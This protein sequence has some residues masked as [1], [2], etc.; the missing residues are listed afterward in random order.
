MLSVPSSIK[1][2]L[3]AVVLVA[4]AP[5]LASAP[6]LAQPMGLPSMGAAS[7]SDLSPAME[8]ALGDLIIAQGRRD[9]TYVHDSEI[10]Q[11]LNDM[12]KRLARYAPNHNLHVDVFGVLS[13]QFNAFALPGGYIGINT[14]LI[15]QAGSESEVAG[16]VAH[17]IA[18][19]TQRHIAR[20]LT[21]QKQSEMI[22]MASVAAALL[23]ALAGGVNVA[24]GVAAFGQA[25]AIDRQ[26]G[27]SRD[28]EREAD[29]VGFHM[30]TK[31]GY[32]PNGLQEMFAKLM[33]NAQFNMGTSGGNAYFST[34]PLSIDRMTDMQ[35]RTQLLDKN[36]YPS[37]DAFWYVRARALVLQTIER[38]DV[39]RV[40]DKL[41]DEG[42]RLKGAQRSAAWLALS[43]L[44]S[45]RRQYEDAKRFLGYAREGVKDSPYIERQA[46]ALALAQD[47]AS[48]ALSISRSAL[49]RWPNHR[50]LAEI[51][52]RALQKLGRHAEA[53]K[54]LQEQIKKWPA[55]SPVLY[56]LLAVNLADSNQPAQARRAM[57]DYYVLTGALPSAM[58]Q[59]QQAR[60]MTQNFHEQSR[61]DAEIR[62]LR[63]RMDQEKALLEK[64]SS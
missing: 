19:V 14:G 29:R 27:Y 22:A 20:G 56:Q 2:K 16:V 41:Q 33:N 24:S 1:R 5:T 18:H 23:A 11:Y 50:A 15:V 44:A 59:L 6:A 25:A 48:S 10:N 46:A 39:T 42:R 13:P 58:A 17:E 53:A 35:N 21:Q 12:G 54:F 45:Q 55:E 62:V 3:A 47:N 26:L 60:E 31:A 52:A 40:V 51:Q 61:I 4:A 64:F 36:Q 49:A 7:G 28:A 37:S 8:R 63:T 32:D 9:P 34:H 30:L 57:A 43:E 38:H